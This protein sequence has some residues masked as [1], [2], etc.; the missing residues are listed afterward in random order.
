LVYSTFLNVEVGILTA[1]NS[2][3]L[4]TTA[5]GLILENVQ[6]KNVLTAVQGPEGTVLAGTTRSLAIAAWGEGYRYTPTD[7]TKPKDPSLQFLG[8]QRYSVFRLTMS[9]LSHNV[10]AF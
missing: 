10:K 7:L 6:L 5:G 2:S 1:Y 3:L 9:G 4:P 8:Q